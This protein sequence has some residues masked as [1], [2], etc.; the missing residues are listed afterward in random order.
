MSEAERFVLEFDEETEEFNQT[1]SATLDTDRQTYLIIDET[2][3][4]M[5]I[6]YRAGISIVTKRKIER[7]VNSYSKS[8]FRL[9]PMAARISQSDFMTA[10]GCAIGTP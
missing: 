1:E 6:S 8:G 4:K 10:S 5:T 9:A 2:E 7:R 3:K